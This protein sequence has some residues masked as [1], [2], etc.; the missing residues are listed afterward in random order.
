MLIDAHA[1]LDQY[2]DDVLPAVLEEIR[3]HQI[4]TIST[5][6][7]LPSYER[8]KA[9]AVRSDLVLATFG[10]H[11]CKAP[12]YAQRLP[13]LA[14]VLM[15]SPMLGEIGLDHRYVEDVSQYPAQRKVFESFLAAA[16][17]QN[18]I[19]NLHTSGAET[20]ILDLLARYEIRRAIV[21]WY[22]G[23]LDLIAAMADRGAFF[24]VGVEVLFSPHIQAIASAIP[25][26]RLLTETDNP[27]GLQWL[28]GTLGMPCRV[29]EIVEKLAELRRTT[30]AIIAQ[31]VETNFAKLLQ[32][33]SWLA[34][35][36]KHWH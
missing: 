22:A 11:P 18:K 28:T 23:P 36:R 24:T 1:H 2:P 20:E 21:H 34:E 8:A 35:L 15:G 33:D 4:L 19:V 14:H 7:D 31:T 27:D 17:E 30:P 9:I 6:M 29:E 10:I 16:R 25:T 5:A 26:D 12:A 13:D 3:A 32:D